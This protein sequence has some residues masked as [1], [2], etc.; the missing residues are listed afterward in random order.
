MGLAWKDQLN[1]WAAVLSTPCIHGNSSLICGFN[2]SFQN[3]SLFMTLTFTL[4]VNG[5]HLL[6]LPDRKEVCSSK[7][8]VCSILILHI[9][10]FLPTHQVGARAEEGRRES[11][12]GLCGINERRIVLKYA[13]TSLVRLETDLERQKGCKRKPRREQPR[14]LSSLACLRPGMWSWGPGIESRD[15]LPAWSLLLPL[16][17]SLL[18]SLCVLMNK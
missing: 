6:G 11:R 8:F 2:H 17:V 15:G 9:S 18:L 3:L 7:Q 14:W 1:S 12:Q 13:L 16:P 10:I 5:K 4:T